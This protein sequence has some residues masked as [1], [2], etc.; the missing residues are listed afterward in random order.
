MRKLV[1]IAKGREARDLYLMRASE[2]I[3]I[4]MN[5]QRD[6]LLTD[7]ELEEAKTR[8]DYFIVKLV[9]NYELI[10]SNPYR[11][12]LH[13]SQ[14]ELLQLND[15]ICKENN[16]VKK[17]NLLAAK[18]ECLGNIDKLEKL[19]TSKEDSKFLKGMSEE[20]VTQEIKMRNGVS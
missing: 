6:I 18:K 7:L 15:L 1:R 10:H 9:R 8:K 12:S 16:S 3:I 17:K 5:D 20:Q 2:R 11:A 14:N 13:A 19:C 4:N